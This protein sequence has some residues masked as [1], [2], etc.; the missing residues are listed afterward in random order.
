MADSVRIWTPIFEAIQYEL[1][2]MLKLREGEAELAQ[3]SSGKIPWKIQN[4]WQIETP[5]VF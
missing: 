2:G 5:A 1:G 4:G 3:S